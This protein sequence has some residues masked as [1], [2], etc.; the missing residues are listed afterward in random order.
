MDRF[1]RHLMSTFFTTGLMGFVARQAFA[2]SFDGIFDGSIGY[3]HPRSVEVALAVREAV[4][5]GALG[6]QALA[7]GQLNAFGLWRATEQLNQF[8][9]RISAVGVEAMEKLPNIAALLAESAL[10]TR[11]VAGPEGF[12]TLVHAAAPQPGDIV[13]VSDLAVLTALNNGSLIGGEALKRKLVIIDATGPEVACLS[14][15]LMT[16]F[17]DGRAPATMSLSNRTAW[18]RRPS[19]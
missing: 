9:S 11:Y 8:G 18:G 6:E 19:D 17:A 13:V 1:R 15:L 5:D 2:C 3:V 12:V 7:P 14:T 16:A 10:W 4:A